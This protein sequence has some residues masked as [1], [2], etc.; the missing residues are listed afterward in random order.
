MT[1]LTQHDI[2]TPQFRT[3]VLNSVKRTGKWDGRR[4]GATIHISQDPPGPDLRI[5]WSVYYGRRRLKGLA[6]NTWDALE[7]IQH[8]VNQ[9]RT[10]EY[11]ECLTL[12][13]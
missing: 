4:R 7:A 9:I 11:R 13:E 12:T 3:R 8:E 5:H 6:S 2:A 10:Q 1:L